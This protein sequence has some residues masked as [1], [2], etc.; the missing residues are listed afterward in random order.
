LAAELAQSRKRRGF[1]L[2]ALTR[3]G[4]LVHEI[5]EKQVVLARL[6]AF[7]PVLPFERTFLALT[8]HPAPFGFPSLAM[9]FGKG[10]DET[11]RF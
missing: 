4:T 10:V 3:E 9:D 2:L 1:W 8:M 11:A 7:S 6:T 5:A